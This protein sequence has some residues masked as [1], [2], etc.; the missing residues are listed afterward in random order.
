MILSW[1]LQDSYFG[2]CLHWLWSHPV[3]VPALHLSYPGL[4]LHCTVCFTLL[5]PILGLV[6]I[7]CYPSPPSWPTS[8]LPLVLS[9]PDLFHHKSHAFP[10]SVWL[11]LAMS[12]HRR[13]QCISGSC[14]FQLIT[15]PALNLWPFLFSLAQASQWTIES[16][17]PNKQ[18]NNDH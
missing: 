1:L 2:F 16:L 5:A 15:C 7:C 11:Y 12:W 9:W 18:T 8:P 14:Y 13:W 17:K 6:W 3:H 10:C 4:Y